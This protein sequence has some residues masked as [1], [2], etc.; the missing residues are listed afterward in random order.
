MVGQVLAQFG[1]ALAGLILVNI[2]PAYRSHEFDYAMRKSGCRALILSRGHKNNDYFSSLRS[3]AP[4]IDDAI[5]GMLASKGL[6]KLEIV[7]RL[8]AEKT[9]G[10]LNFDDVARP[11][12][13]DERRPLA[14]FGATLQFDDPINIQFTSG[15]TGAPKGAT[16]T[17]HNIVNNGYF[18]GKAMRLTP[19]DRL[20]IPV[21]CHRRGALHAHRGSGDDRCGRLL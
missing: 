19:D 8:G 12:A 16:L 7:I 1:A 4:E 14:A 18:I 21:P 13:D 15:T 3:V 5:P 10:M 20:C 2:N 9:P 11:A 6:P 17:H